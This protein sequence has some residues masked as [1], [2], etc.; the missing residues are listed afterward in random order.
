MLRFTPTARGALALCALAFGPVASAAAPIVPP[1][2]ASV[3]VSATSNSPSGP[4]V[5]RNA[6]GGAGL[7]DTAADIF[8]A[9]SATG[10]AT[11]D[12]FGV[13][14]AASVS[15]SNI[16]GYTTSATAAAGSVNAFMIVPRAGF[17]GSSALVRIPYSFAGSFNSFPSLAACSSC[18]GAVDVR[19]EV[20]GLT[21][22]FYFLGAHSQGTMNNANFVAGG[23]AMA[24]GLEGQL[25]VNTVLYVRAGL[26][27]N[28][29]CQAF[30]GAPCGMSAL[31][32]SALS[33]AG[34]SPDDVDIVWALTPTLA[35]EPAP[36]ALLAMGVVGLVLAGRRRGS[37]KA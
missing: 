24:G 16:H 27:T 22:S 18:F 21:Q 11:V 23:V 6:S 10:S 15:G 31:F 12:A 1:F 33:Y 37:Q 34:F 17:T 30:N 7:T 8:G 28:V 5:T 26:S 29:H 14:A 20:D 25:P 2:S 4:G 36:G 3:G 13:H 32:G 35:P 19:L 9:D